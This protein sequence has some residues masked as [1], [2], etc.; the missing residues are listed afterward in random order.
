MS[1]WPN[2]WHAKRPWFRSSST[3][4][5][6]DSDRQTK[7]VSGP[8]RWRHWHEKLSNAAPRKYNGY[9][10]EICLNANASNMD[11]SILKVHLPNGGFNVVKCGEATDI[12]VSKHDS[13]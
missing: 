10:D 2:L 13:S 3:D 9:C 6:S 11:K 8:H 1:N 4:S 5:Q 12:K 7:L